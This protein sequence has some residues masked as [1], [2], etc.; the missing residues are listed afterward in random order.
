MAEQQ[1]IHIGAQVFTSD[2]HEVGKVIETL[3]TEFLVEGGHLVKHFFAFQYAAAQKATPERVDLTWTEVD[4]K[5]T[6][7]VLA[8]R[9]KHGREQH[10]TQ[11]GI[12]PSRKVPTY[13][14]VQ[15]TTG[16]PPSGEEDV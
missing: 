1:A 6:W 9:D 10:V 12:A 2:G 16:G 11:V 5:Q 15:T 8:L 7:N 4:L 13:D 3:T 14:E